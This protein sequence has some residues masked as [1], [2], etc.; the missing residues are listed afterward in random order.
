MESGEPGKKSSFQIQNRSPSFTSP[1][2]SIKKI[3]FVAS[4]AAGVQFG[5]ALQLSLL[6]PYVQLLSIPHKWASLIWL[7]AP[8][9]GM[10]VQP[11]VGYHSDR[12]TSR[13]GRRRPFIAA[14]AALVAT[15]VVPIG[16]AADL[17]NLFGDSLSTQTKPRTIVVFVIGF[18]ILDVANNMLQGPCRA[19]LAD[20]SGNNH[21]KKQAANVF[22]SFFM[23]IG[24]VLG[25]A[26]GS[27][28][29]LHKIFPFATT[30]ACDVYCANL[31]NCFFFS[32]LLLLTLTSIALTYVHEKPWSPEPGNAGNVNGREIEV[33]EAAAAKAT[34]VPFF[35]EIF[36]ALKELNRPMW[37]LLAVT[38]INWI[39]WFPFLLFDTD[40]MGRKVYGGDSVGN[41]LVLRLYDSGGTCR[42]IGTHVELCGSG[43]HVPWGGDLGAWVTK[44]AKSSRRFITVDGVVAPFPPP[45][46]IKAGALSL[47]AALGIPLAITYSIPFALASIFSSSSGAGQG[48][49]LG[50]LN[51]AIVIP[52]ICIFEAFPSMQTYAIKN[53]NDIPRA[54]TWRRILL[55]DLEELLSYTT[56]NDE[57]NCPLQRLTPKEADLATD[58]SVLYVKTMVHDVMRYGLYVLR[59]MFLRDDNGALRGE[60]SDKVDA[61]C[62]VFLARW[63]S[64][65]RQRACAIT[66]LYTPLVPRLHKKKPDSPVIV[67]EA[68]PI[69]Q[70]AH[71]IVQEASPTV[72]EPDSHGVICRHIDKPPPVPDMMDASWLSYELPTSTIPQ[73]ERGT[74][75]DTITD[76]TLWA[77]TAIDFYLHEWSQGCYSDICKL[78][79]VMHLFLDRSWWGILLGVE[80]NDYFEGEVD[81]VFIP[82]LECRH[83]LL[84]EIQLPSLKT[85]VYDNMLNYIPL[86]DLRDLICKGWSAHLAKYLDAIDYW[87]NS[88]K[89]K[90]KKFKVTMIRDDTTPQKMEG[91]RGDCGPLVCMCLER[92]M[93]R[94]KQFLPPTDRDRGAVGLWF[95]HFMARAI[96]ARRC[97]PAS[98]C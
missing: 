85:I 26:A 67:Q 60:Q 73:Q 5:W 16:F 30:K 44:L 77:K 14:G 20:I 1:P 89:K 38:C 8:I 84:I 58:W 24:N 63:G 10:L 39:A 12:C 98:A 88:G 19:L 69:V 22:F 45:A 49:S 55:L 64:R 71:I 97:L 81:K 68:S 37:I 28:T 32:I 65:I 93:T 52:Q 46:G 21:K 54:I 23:A 51:L 70:E 11:I 95:R 36:G 96:Y 18:W 2:F 9:S 80:D 6:T 41:N 53:S 35:G 3:I 57:A 43:F 56:M 66:S 33:E 61:L 83:W 40:W 13:F 72:Q 25:F 76:N 29:H 79:D 90:Q 4:I 47:F 86:S 78:D 17:G 91:A 48:L 42:R 92:L 15:A 27:Y 75:P 62:R 59:W 50:V 94:S 74:L 34:P 31:K 82:V 7:C 87:T